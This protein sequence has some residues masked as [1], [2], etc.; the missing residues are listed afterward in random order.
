MVSREGEGGQR[1]EGGARQ[2]RYDD[3][4]KTAL[5]AAMAAVA[6]A[7]STTLQ[8]RCHRRTK[9]DRLFFFIPSNPSIHPKV[10]VP[11]HFLRP[12]SSPHIFLSKRQNPRDR[13]KGTTQIED[14]EEREGRK[15]EEEWEKLDRAKLP[16]F[17]QRDGMNERERETRQ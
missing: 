17:F 4:R 8:L 15:V 5:K 14:A 7:L 16:S 1:S 2:H 12:H 10:F 3:T 11:S 13:R 9:P 6:C